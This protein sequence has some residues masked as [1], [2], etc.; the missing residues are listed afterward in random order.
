MNVLETYKK[1]ISIEYEKKV[2]ELIPRIRRAEKRLKHEQKYTKMWYREKRRLDKLMS[3][4]C[5]QY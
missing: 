5:L 1:E 4:G 2:R 3:A